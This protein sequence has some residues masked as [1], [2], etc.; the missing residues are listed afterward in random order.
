MLLS[1]LAAYAEEKYQIKE[2]HKWPELP[3]FSVL[4]DPQTGKWAAL[5][6][7][8]WD[9]EK[10]EE[11]LRCDIKCGRQCITEFQVPYVTNAFRMKGNKWVGV[12]FDD[13]TDKEIVFKLFD[14][15]VRALEQRGFNIVLESADGDGEAG[16]KYSDTLLPLESL[17]GNYDK[18]RTAQREADARR[19]EEEKRRREAQERERASRIDSALRSRAGAF[20][21]PS[22]QGKGRT[23]GAMTRE[24]LADQVP[25]R[26]FEMM[27]LYEYG[28][29]SFEHKCRNFYRQGKFMEDYEDDAPWSGEFRRYFATYHDLNLNQLRGYFAWRT[30]VRR[31]VYRRIT[32]SLAYMYIYELLNGIGVSSPEECLRRMKEFETGYLD[33]GIGDPSMRENLRRWRMEYAVLQGASTEEV[34]PFIDPELIERDLKLQ[35]LL[36]P[37]KYTDEEVYEA[38]SV[39]SGGKT[40][41][42]SV[43]LK[44]PGRGKHLFAEVWR[45]MSEH[46]M[47]DGWNIFTACFGKMRKFP[48]HPLA[49]A[50]YMDREERGDTV[51]EINACRKFVYKNGQWSEMR[52]DGLFFDKYRIGAIMHEADRQL[53]RYLKTG[54]YLREKE[55]EEWITPYVEAVIEADREAALEAAKPR[56]TIDLSGLDKIRRDAQIT[57]DSLLTEEEMQEHETGGTGPE[58][59]DKEAPAVMPDPGEPVARQEVS[60]PVNL[61]VENEKKPVHE[62][63]GAVTIKIPSLDETHVQ[64]LLTLMR[65]GSA[66][67][68]IRENYLMPSVVADTINEALF[69]EIGDNVLE[70]DGDE[71]TLVEDYREEL[72][73]IL[74]GEG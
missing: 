52:Y 53:R 17:R 31:G 33:S 32:T 21:T 46:Y 65:G 3:G 54:H 12:V 44:E 55:G 25:P 37:E 74:E 24:P 70:C 40:E 14:R 42:S 43:I 62:E 26:I 34:L 5:L 18:R 73:L 50:V 35:V 36:R 56:V 58:A 69:D 20:V 29:S 15:A 9:Y 4:A 66:A 10:G 59:P 38:L 19:K 28:S 61:S 27:K 60:E 30:L 41:K 1:D 22:F 39:L 71:I 11:L 49:N 72:T 67:E 51:Y 2:E 57:R 8:R 47:D 13:R 7:R 45:Y 16:K 63:T 68:L 6:M 48:W 23:S 64:I